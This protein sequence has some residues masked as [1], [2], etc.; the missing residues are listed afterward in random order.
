ML[1]ILSQF[2]PAL[3]VWATHCSFDSIQ[4]GPRTSWTFNIV[5]IGELWCRS[6]LFSI[7]THRVWLGSKRL[8]IPYSE[9]KVI[10]DC[11]ILPK[12]FSNFGFSNKLFEHKV[13]KFVVSREAPN[14]RQMLLHCDWIMLWLDHH[15]CFPIVWECDL[16][17]TL[18][19]VVRSW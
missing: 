12:K 8:K 16:P 17:K 14:Y 15:I 3:W 9:C 10:G 5:W 11:S 13:R 6:A 18:S 4:T 19:W 2:V 7:T 1:I